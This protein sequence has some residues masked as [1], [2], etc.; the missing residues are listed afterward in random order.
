MKLSLF[1]LSAASVVPVPGLELG[2]EEASL[3]TSHCDEC[4]EDSLEAS[5]KDSLE[6]SLRTSHCDECLE[7]TVSSSAGAAQRHPHM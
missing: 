3:R 1:I 2:Q 4:L 7:V 6:A 5:L